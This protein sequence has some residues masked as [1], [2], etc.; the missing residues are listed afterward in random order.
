MNAL[1]RFDTTALNQLNKA[2]IG[3]DRMFNTAETRF[4]NGT[5]YPPYN[6]IKHSDNSYEIEIAVAGFSLDDIDV[7]INQNELI[8]RGQRSQEETTNE[9]EYLHRGLAYREFQKSF[10]LA[11]HMEVG[12]AVIQDGVLSIKITRI[13]P[14][15]LKPRKIQVLGFT[16]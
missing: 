1:T 9:V 6:I 5:N 12:E 11:E 13:I 10:T 3:F 8:I 15:A 14:E 4:Q 2:L 16:K 7:E